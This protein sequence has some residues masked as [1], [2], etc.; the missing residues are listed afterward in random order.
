MRFPDGCGVD[1]VTNPPAL[2]RRNFC[3]EHKAAVDAEFE[4]LKPELLILQL[5]NQDV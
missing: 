4:R 2:I 5:A 1:L 3:E